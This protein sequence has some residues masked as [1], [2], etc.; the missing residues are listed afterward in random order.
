VS[1]ELSSFVKT[2]ADEASYEF[3]VT[4]LITGKF[5]KPGLK[6]ILS[7]RIDRFPCLF[8]KKG[9]SKTTIVDNKNNKPVLSQ[10][11]LLDLVFACS[12]YLFYAP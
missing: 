3:R 4:G 2:T 10:Q 1:K 9:C 11:D 6:D 8:V 5:L 7:L 12:A